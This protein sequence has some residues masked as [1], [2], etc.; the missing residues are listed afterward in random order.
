MPHR[1]FSVAA[2]VIAALF[3]LSG[4]ARAQ[5]I[6]DGDCLAEEQSQ[7]GI[8]HFD[9]AA[10]VHPF[11]DMF[12]LWLSPNIL[13][14]WDTVGVHAFMNAVVDSTGGGLFPRLWEYFCIADVDT[15][16][17]RIAF[18]AENHDK[19]VRHIR[20]SLLDEG[21]GGNANDSTLTL[22][23][24]VDSTTILEPEDVGNGPGLAHEMGHVIESANI[25]GALM[26]GWPTEGLACAAEV[27]MG[28]LPQDK[29]N[30]PYFDT[31]FASYR[32][33]PSV[34]HPYLRYRMF[35]AY[36][37]SHYAGDPE[38]DT[39]DLIY[40]WVRSTAGDP[41]VLP[42]APYSHPAG[43]AALLDDEAGIPGS[44]GAEKMGFLFHRAALALYADTTGVYNGDY[45]FGDNLSARDSRMFEWW[46]TGALHSRAVPPV[47]TLGT[48]ELEPVT[49]DTYLDAVD[50]SLKSTYCAT[51]P[52]G[53]RTW[54]TDYLVFKAGPS[55]VDSTLYVGFESKE[56]VPLPEDFLLKVGYIAYASD[57]D[58]VYDQEILDIVETVSEVEV[59][60][61]V[62]R[63]EIAVPGFADSVK[64]VV[65]VCSLVQNPIAEVFTH[66]ADHSITCWDEDGFGECS[67]PHVPFLLTYGYAPEVIAVPSDQQQI[68]TAINQALPGQVVRVSPRQFGQSYPESIRL[69]AGVPVLRAIGFDPPAIEAPA[70]SAFCVTL[71]PDADA[72][73]VLSDFELEGGKEGVVHL[74]G[75]GKVIEC[76]ISATDTTV[77]VVA[78]DDAELN[79][80]LVLGGA[81]GIQ[82][83]DSALVRFCTV[84]GTE[85]DGISADAT[86][87]IANTIVSGV[88]DTANSVGIRGGTVN[89]CLAPEG[90]EED[91]GT[92]NVVEDPLYCDPDL[93][94]LRVD[95]YANPDN[96]LSGEF[97]GV[98]STIGCIGG[99]LQRDA[100]YSWQDLPV[101]GTVTIPEGLALT[102]TAGATLAFPDSTGIVVA[103]TLTAAGEQ[104][105]QYAGVVL[106]GVSETPGAWNGIAVS[107]S[108]AEI[109]LD[110]CTIR[111]AVACIQ[112]TA[113]S[114]AALIDLNGAVM[115]DFSLAGLYLRPEASDGTAELS[116]A[117]LSVW[118]DSAPLAVVVD[119]T[120]AG[121]SYDVTMDNLKATASEYALVLKSDPEADPNTDAIT[122]FD[123]STGEARVA[124][125]IQ[126]CSPVI[127][128]ALLSVS[129]I[130]L[131][132][133]GTGSV[134]VWGNFA[135]CDTAI[136]MTGS[137]AASVS[138][139]VMRGPV[140]IA[141]Y[142]STSLDSIAITQA[143]I[144]TASLAAVVAHGACSVQNADVDIKRGTGIALLG[145]GASVSDS[146]VAIS[147]TD[148]AYVG[149]RLDAASGDTATALRC[150]V[151]VPGG[152]G[153][154]SD[155][156][157]A[158]QCTVVDS[159]YGIRYSG[160]APENCIVASCGTAGYT[161][162][163]GSAQAEYCIADPASGFG[164]GTQGTGSIVEYPR[165]CDEAN[166]VYTLRGDS[167]GNP[168]VNQS[169]EP[170]GAYPVACLYGQ[171]VRSATLA[172]GPIAV[173]GHTS[174][175]DGFTLTLSHG[176]ELVVDTANVVTAGEA[177]LIDVAGGALTASGTV[178]DSVSIHCVDPQPGAWGGIR[179][180]EAE[181]RVL[182]N[183]AEIRHAATCIGIGGYTCAP[184]DS[185]Y[186]IEELSV[187]GCLLSEFSHNGIWMNHDLADSTST[188]EVT[189]TTINM[190]DANGSGIWV[191]RKEGANEDAG[192]LPGYSPSLTSVTIVGDP[193]GARGIYVNDGLTAGYP[194]ASILDVF[195]SGLTMG[196][197]IE[198]AGLSGSIWSDAGTMIE[199]CKYG[200]KLRGG[201]TPHIGIGP[202]GEVGL[203]IIGC[204]T[205]ILT[206]D[207]ALVSVEDVSIEPTTT[208]IGIYTDGHSGGTFE[209]VMITGGGTGLKAYATEE[210]TLRSSA[211]TGFKT[212]GVLVAV[213]GLPHLGEEGDPGNNFIYSTETGVSKYV[214]A[215][216]RL[217]ELG[218]VMAEENWWD[219]DGD[220]P[221]AS[222]FTANVDYSPWKTTQYN[223]SARRIAIVVAPPIVP[224]LG[225]RPNPFT[226]S[227]EVAFALPA[228]S[229]DYRVE[230]FDT[231]GR[232]VRV[233]DQGTASIGVERR[234]HW[235][236]RDDSGRVIASGMYFVR[237]T[238]PAVTRVVK[239]VSVR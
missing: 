82:A 156:G 53:W 24:R 170:I 25:S 21:E 233:I 207:S 196:T 35:Y 178:Q 236:G 120:V 199:N 181:S 182:L 115:E 23:I 49:I 98:S 63:A 31:S 180:T 37:H 103:G 184:V 145:G 239:I 4:T 69:K 56:G 185:S 208:G 57:E 95:S 183:Y 127:S 227:G 59:Y 91:A 187:T 28:F 5:W 161:R 92:G 211:L 86:A 214:S 29:S 66:C 48:A 213:A 104:P 124:G 143:Q 51:K 62:I 168:L 14:D 64:A 8:Q 144:G 73:T 149:I 202:T 193:S 190:T 133:E 107:D 165:F 39:D 96:N 87:T 116:A 33:Q 186:P 45:G 60:N 16:W 65:V 68:Q 117:D 154:V 234:I 10:G 108:S 130:G 210:H 34:T 218:P 139:G 220:A 128:N 102:L 100:T 22:R 46:N 81:T 94:T 150:F 175:P 142:D 122:T 97:I 198:I 152:S 2:L 72:S 74:Q 15:A 77:G 164:S 12:D 119:R 158:S 83:A 84:E 52:L 229:G 58:P 140:G 47:F 76:V 75:A 230:L 36:L 221:S 231:L 123:V 179:A 155:N 110:Y 203:E 197:G 191:G 151:T 160:A 27:V 42:V 201:S 146:R 174:I 212:Y 163:G 111:H 55:A 85:G 195:V 192:Q 50:D 169:G 162:D 137:M 71:P 238:S 70:E 172:S 173:L 188:F 225:F 222:M 7:S 109:A 79:L 1:S 17:D 136:V 219:P 113:A 9:P 38:D 44:G 78:A 88:V 112:D 61:G 126:D 105:V 20:I 80:C 90:I 40:R 167:Y 171:L 43:F 129:E 223:P 228:G 157:M 235:D 177:I 237:M 118:G 159:D 135:G 30:V 215:K 54:G 18:W 13:A 32:S 41:L 176:A 153:I 226:G 209:S 194:A 216:T 26:G 138:Y 19:F 93:R 232:R 217:G 3:L 141:M 224:Q 206:S 204:T 200:V 106:S 114:A 166:G 99:T 6:I 101:T 148:S 147:Q 67:Q 132:L 125:L 189:S 11:V 134:M 205:G 121:K 89:Y 131:K